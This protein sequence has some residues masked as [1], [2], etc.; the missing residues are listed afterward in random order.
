MP[1][2]GSLTLLMLATLAISGLFVL[3]P[4]LDIAISSLFG[5]AQGFPIASQGW[6]EVLRQVLMWATRL[7]ALATLIWL[8]ATLARGAA[9]R[10]NW[11]LPAFAM[12]S[13]ILGPWLLVN[14]LFKSH[15]GRARP[16]DIAEFGGD[17]LFTPA[18]KIADQCAANC[19]FVSGEAGMSVATALLIAILFAPNLRR[20][21]FWLLGAFGTLG[22]G[23]RV[24]VGAHFASDAILSGLFCALI[25]LAGYRLFN[26]AAHHQPNLARAIWADLRRR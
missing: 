2:L 8:L 15:W 7:A 25:I 14:E 17:A 20:Y 11:R 13:F 9:A 5:G 6:A 4:Q 1:K 26:I 12:L 3:W 22:A 16:R 24:V 10:V 23:L 21:Q 19:S 18:W